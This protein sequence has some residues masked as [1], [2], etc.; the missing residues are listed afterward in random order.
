[1][2]TIFDLNLA[3]SNYLFKIINQFIARLIA[4]V[5]SHIPVMINEKYFVGNRLIEARN[6]IAA[7]KKH[8]IAS[9]CPAHHDSADASN[10]E[11]PF[12]A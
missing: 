2:I 4:L 9:T 12:Q 5:V 6:E 3:L 8:N 11:S 7:E 10:G 1:M